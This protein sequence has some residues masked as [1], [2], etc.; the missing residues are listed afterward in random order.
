MRSFSREIASFMLSIRLLSLFVRIAIVSP[1]RQEFCKRKDQLTREW[2]RGTSRHTPMIG[3]TAN[4]F[5]ED[6]RQCFSAT[7][8]GFMRKS[9]QEDALVWIPAQMYS[10]MA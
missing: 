5:A 1:S 9:F 2:A 7:M 8:D 3:L 4:A 6:R 10:R